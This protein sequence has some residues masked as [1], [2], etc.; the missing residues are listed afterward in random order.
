[1][2]ACP[3]DEGRPIPGNQTFGAADQDLKWAP[4]SADH[5]QL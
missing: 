4:E 3:S 1:V 5:G 2:A